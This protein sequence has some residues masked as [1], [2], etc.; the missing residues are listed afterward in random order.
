M[1]Q[2]WDPALKLTLPV[3]YCGFAD[4]TGEAAARKP[5]EITAVIR[6]LA[7]TWVVSGVKQDL[8]GAETC[9]YK[10]C[11]NSLMHNFSPIE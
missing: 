1:G 11:H 8:L 10:A 9:T 3:G 2:H 6:I 7:N 5:L 4:T